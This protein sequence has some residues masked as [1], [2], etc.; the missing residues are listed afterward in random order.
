MLR[1]VCGGGGGGYL[2]KDAFLSVKSDSSIVKMWLLSTPVVRIRS[3][4]SNSDLFISPQNIFCI[5]HIVQTFAFF[6]HSEYSSFPDYKGCGG[7]RRTDCVLSL[8]C[9]RTQAGQLPPLAS[10]T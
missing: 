6:S 7:Q 2:F 8:H 10:G 3:E 4:L 1:T 5:L 9:Q